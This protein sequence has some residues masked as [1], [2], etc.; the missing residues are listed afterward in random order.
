MQTLTDFRKARQR[1]NS[2]FA[3]IDLRPAQLTPE[4]LKE[5]RKEYK[6]FVKPIVE[7]TFTTQVQKGNL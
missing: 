6:E 5:V 7:H 2:I 1:E 3:P 4:E